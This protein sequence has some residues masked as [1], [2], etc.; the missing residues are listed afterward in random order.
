MIRRIAT[1]LLF[2]ATLA[3]SKEPATRPAKVDSPTTKP[4][5]QAAE[6]LPSP[7]E[8]AA[9]IMA[10]RDQKNDLLK[11]AFFDLDQPVA[12]KPPT[13]ALLNDNALTLQSLVAR[14][15]QARDEKNVRAILI[16]LGETSFNRAQAQEIREA[17]AEISKN[18]KRT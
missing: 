15:H 3:V 17:L 9:R 6:K 7:K 1:F 12:E 18:G 5:V 16:N 13:F 14:L 11:V 2:S 8:L 4:A 10:K